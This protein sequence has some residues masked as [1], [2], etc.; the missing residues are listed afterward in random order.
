MAVP[1]KCQK[2]C[3]ECKSAFYKKV[4]RI[5]FGA[6]F[7]NGKKMVCYIKFRVYL[8]AV[9]KKC[10]KVPKGVAEWFFCIK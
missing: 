3:P 8:V 5:H 9:A 10:Q 2:E 4:L 7:I 1:E 6:T